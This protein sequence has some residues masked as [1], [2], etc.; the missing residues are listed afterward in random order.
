MI[1]ALIKG[2][3]LG[4]YLA[5]SVGPVV[6]TIIKQ[7]LNNG[8]EGGFSFVAGVWLSDILLVFLSNAFSEMV[9]KLLEHKAFIGYAGSAFLISMG[10][11]FVFIKKFRVV[12]DNEVALPKFRKRDYA[13]L[14]ASGFLVN[15]LNPGVFLFWLVTATSFSL[16]HTFQQRIIIFSACI[17]LNMLAD[18][19]KVLLAG[20]LRRRLTVHNMTV[21]NKISGS[22]LIGF[23]LFLLWG[24]I[25]AID[26]L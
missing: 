4:L 26:K 12:N 10:V 1:D 13:K 15:T 20:K 25:F 9:A 22:I 3:A 19:G 17:L 11:Y 5:I 18:I 6:F 8:K 14:M 16:S 2:L 21:I 7:S 24:A 23:G